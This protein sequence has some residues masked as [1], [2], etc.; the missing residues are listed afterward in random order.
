MKKAVKTYIWILLLPILFIP[1]SFLNSKVLVEVFGCGCRQGFNAN[2]FTGIFVIII[3]FLT[4]ILVTISYIKEYGLKTRKSVL[5]YIVGL[6]VTS[7]AIGFFAIQFI[8]Y[9]LWD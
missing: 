8:F 4:L 6:L 3:S 9:H 1:Y 7:V 5:M 2:T